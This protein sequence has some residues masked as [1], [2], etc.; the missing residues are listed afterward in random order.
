MTRAEHLSWAKQRALEILNAG[1]ITGA[2][3][4]LAS[5]LNKHKETQGHTGIELGMGEL[6]GGLLNTP[7]KMKNHIEGYN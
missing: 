2:F 7:E 6:V 4:S 1:D 3:A 5:D